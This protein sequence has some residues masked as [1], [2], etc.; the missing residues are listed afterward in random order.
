MWWLDIS[1]TGV[2]V[3]FEVEVELT[4]STDLVGLGAMDKSVVPGVT[5]T[6]D[7]IPDPV[8]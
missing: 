5:V 3:V 8:E 1:T 7:H 2:S 4:V 6:N